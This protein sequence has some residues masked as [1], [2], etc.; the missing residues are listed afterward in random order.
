MK[1]LC[2]RSQLDIKSVGWQE[3]QSQIHFSVEL[4]RC[5]QVVDLTRIAL[6]AGCMHSWLAKGCEVTESSILC[7]L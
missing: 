5:W 3:R 4:L 1:C 2:N 6:L 7:R